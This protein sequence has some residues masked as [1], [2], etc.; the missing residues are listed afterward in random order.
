[1]KYFFVGIG[2]I[3][4][5]GLA[6]FLRQNGHTVAGYDKTETD[7]TRELVQEGIPVTYQMGTLRPTHWDT[8]VYTPAVGEH[9]PD[10][11]AARSAGLPLL[12]RAQLLG[13]ISKQYATLAVG[14]THGKTTT[15]AMLATFLKLGGVDASA[16]VGGIT[17][18]FGSN[19]IA[20]T[21][22]LLVAEADEFD[23]SFLWLHPVCSI[24][25]S[26]D[27]DHLDIYGQP[28]ELLHTYR[29][30]VA[31]VQP[32]GTVLLHE[33]LRELAFVVPHATVRYYGTDSPDI[34]AEHL[35]LNGPQMVFDY[36]DGRTCIP[37]VELNVPGTH[38][39]NNALAA[40]T[41][42]LQHGVSAEALKLAVA[43][44]RGVKRRFEILLNTPRVAYVDDYA[45]HP[46]ELQATLR[47]VRALWPGRRVVVAFQPHLFTRTRDFAEGFAAALDEA[48]A[49]QLIHIYP[50]R[51][52][53]LPGVSSETIRALMK[54]PAPAPIILAD[55]PQVLEGT[56]QSEPVVV[57]TVGAGDI[58][59]RVQPTLEFL[60]RLL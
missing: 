23:R 53:P 21:A 34:H 32:G 24:L 39:L 44:F 29:Q 56:L 22:P 6:R 49:V 46:T 33:H 2:G 1:M 17:A 14:G 58:D 25:T 11:L 51:E 47:S 10:V 27:P 13:E 57:L 60:K 59:T 41:L 42:A 43:G 38:N 4:M 37:G 7:L 8:V 26:A 45:H 55:F 9:N 54:R 19:Y 50:A 36:V 31:Q 20:G 28:E 52:E 35:R 15:S 3:G 12:K 48:D 5:S 40:M 30:F 16:F 18:N